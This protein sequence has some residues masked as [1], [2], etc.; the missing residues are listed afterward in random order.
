MDHQS[1]F[2]YIFFLIGYLK[3][4]PKQEEAT[5]KCEE[6]LKALVSKPGCDGLL[7]C[8]CHL[9]DDSD[10]TMG[11]YRRLAKRLA[12]RERDSRVLVFLVVYTST[13]R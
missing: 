4:K 8:M 9:R 7:A 12:A 6:I 5:L 10:G 3:V 13:L 2:F 11:F 1:S